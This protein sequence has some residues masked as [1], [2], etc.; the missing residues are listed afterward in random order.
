MHFIW[1][2]KITFFVF[3]FIFF[4]FITYYILYF[5]LFEMLNFDLHVQF[6]DLAAL[7]MATVGGE[8]EHLE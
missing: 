7:E 2:Y 1:H 6:R 3:Y 5:L 8:D 4:I